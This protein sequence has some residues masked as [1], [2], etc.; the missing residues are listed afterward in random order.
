[1]I[2]AIRN[3]GLIYLNQELDKKGKKLIRD[4]KEFSK[5][6]EDEP[7]IIAKLL[8]E[9]VG[10]DAEDIK[11]FVI[12]D[13]TNEIYEEEYDASNDW[14]YLYKK[15][16]GSK[17]PYIVPSFKRSGNDE[18]HTNETLRRLKEC[19]GQNIKHLELNN[20]FIQSTEKIMNHLNDNNRHIK[21][22]T[23]FYTFILKDKYLGERESI[24]RQFI[25]ILCKDFKTAKMKDTF[26]HGICSL[27]Q[28]KYEIYGSASP[29]KFFVLEKEGFFPDFDCSYSWR[30]FPVCKNCALLLAIGK[31][32][33]E[34]HLETYIAHPCYILPSFYF[35]EKR[36]DFDFLDD[37]VDMASK[38]IFI[39]VE[40]I[41]DIRDIEKY[42][43][44]QEKI[45][46]L[47][48]HFLF[49]ER[50][51]AAF[52]IV[53]HIENI[54]PS[55]I[56][57]IFN[58]VKEVNNHY[59]DNKWFPLAEDRRYELDLTFSFLNRIFMVKR[60]KQIGKLKKNTLITSLDLI[61]DIFHN[62]K[63]DKN[64]LF[65]DF[66]S[67]L[68]RIYLDQISKKKDRIRRRLYLEI[69]ELIKLLEFLIKM[70]V[71]NMG[72]ILS[73]ATSLGDANL[74]EFFNEYKK[75]YTE[76][77][78]RTCFVAGVLFGKLESIQL[79]RLGSNPCLTWLKSMNLSK[80]EIERLYWKI[81]EKFKQYHN[82]PYPAFTERVKRVA[83]DFDL[84]YSA[85]GEKWHITN[86]EIKFYFTMGWTL[87]DKFLPT[88]KEEKEE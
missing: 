50:R 20:L 30:S 49:Y 84:Q 7:E 35:I 70:E 77:A 81:I 43:L 86:N 46:C 64:S 25:D 61:A 85:S 55:Q 68:Q 37:F 13:S 73:T 71:L 66:C 58:V 38:R 87:Y 60:A 54:L 31:V 3:L 6:I 34:R 36:T 72:E 79:A 28:G 67:H 63:I 62:K 18:K 12:S 59:Y 27:C 32:Y 9:K 53:K 42:I 44:Q 24:A 29:L 65:T 16:F 41:E 4:V 14:K 69:T 52:N 10:S 57:R 1:M 21:G 45:P 56:T 80:G 23:S 8:S 82:H 47:T 75:V 15:S 19:L 76:P 78:K 83:Q 5:I 2:E 33:M 51:N 11:V 26:G 88:T 22:K 40:D 74:S 48:Y 17:S 39:R